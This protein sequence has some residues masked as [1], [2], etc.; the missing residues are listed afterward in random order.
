MNTGEHIIYRPHSSPSSINSTHFLSEFFFKLFPV[1]TTTTPKLQEGRGT[2]R[3]ALTP[4]PSSTVQCVFVLPNRSRSVKRAQ[5]V[6]GT[7]RD[8]VVGR[9]SAARVAAA[10]C[11]HTRSCSRVSRERS[12]GDRGRSGEV[13]G[14]RRDKP[15]RCDRSPAPRRDCRS[16]PAVGGGE[17]RGGDQEG[18]R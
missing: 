13:G 6:T 11:V 2:N 10:E 17:E 5:P 12:S 1:G 16:A 9:S 4:E 15:R 8:G 3:R 7:Q 14:G 18:R